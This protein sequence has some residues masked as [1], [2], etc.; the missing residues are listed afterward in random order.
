MENIK[1]VLI[2][3][4]LMSNGEL[5]HYGRSLGFIGKKQSERVQANATK[6]ARGREMIVALNPEVA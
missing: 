2:E 4:V 1:I 3:A 6:I 5:I